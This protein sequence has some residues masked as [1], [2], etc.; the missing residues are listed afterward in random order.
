MS[1]IE[2]SRKK[3]PWVLHVNAGSCNGCNLELL[4]CL[5]PRYDV[6]RF[7]VYNTDNPK[8]ADVM[9]VIGPVTLKYKPIIQNLYEQMPDPKVVMAVGTCAST[10]GIYQGCYGQ[11]GG[12]DKI[13]PV[14]VYV[15]GCNVTPEA[16]IDGLVLAL[17]VLNEKER[18]ILESKKAK[19]EA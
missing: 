5:T 3:S 14:D 12:V 13:L 19:G 4:S 10:G 1:L 11:I 7:G 6:S 2:L 17:D 9:I 16:I 18:K 8:H 15:P